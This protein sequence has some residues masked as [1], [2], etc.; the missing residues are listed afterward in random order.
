MV[1]NRYLCNKRSNRPSRPDSILG[2][3][4]G[5]NLI[6]GSVFSILR[7]NYRGVESAGLHSYICLFLSREIQK[8]KKKIS[9]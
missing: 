9:S 1:R 8:D 4:S 6:C 5:G 2:E 3:L 7:F